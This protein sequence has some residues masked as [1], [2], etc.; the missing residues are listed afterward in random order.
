VT[1]AG[2]TCTRA[3][4]TGL[5]CA[6]PGVASGGTI[7]F[8]ITAQ[9]TAVGTWQIPMNLAG[10]QTDPDPANNALARNVIVN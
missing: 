9:A 4:S 10:H 6:I 1:A 8:T 7:S 2:A 5:T 3:P